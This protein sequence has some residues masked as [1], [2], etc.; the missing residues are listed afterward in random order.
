SLTAARCL[1]KKPHSHAGARGSRFTYPI[2]SP[3]RARIRNANLSALLSDFGP[4]V[5]SSRA[6]VDCDPFNC[7]PLVKVPRNA[8]MSSISC[9]LSAGF[10]PGAPPNGGEH[11]EGQ[12]RDRDYGTKHRQ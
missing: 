12:R 11:W 8:T 4:P 9:S 3:P 5:S 10:P 7:H 1:T 6:E 2:A